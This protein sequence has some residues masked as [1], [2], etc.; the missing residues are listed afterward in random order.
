M[1]HSD[2]P[3][4]TL[5]FGSIILLAACSTAATS[6]AAVPTVLPSPSKAPIMGDRSLV[7][8]TYRV[9]SALPLEVNLTVGDGWNGLQDWALLN[10]NGRTA[11][12]FYRVVSLFADPCAW[13]RNDF[14]PPVGPSVDDLVNAMGTFTARTP[15]APQAITLAGWSGKVVEWSVPLDAAFDDCDDGMYS[16]WRFSNWPADEFGMRFHQAPGQVDRIYALDVDG[17]RLIIDENWTPRTTADERAELH[18]VVESL[19]ISR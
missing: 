9:G 3:S 19:T 6:P 17:T 4:L 7:A 13:K 5:I 18:D 15:T 8:G 10:S 1:R 2:R 11:V 14:D 16:S 12:S